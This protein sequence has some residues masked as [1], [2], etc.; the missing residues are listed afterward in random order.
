MTTYAKDPDTTERYGVNWADRLAADHATITGVGWTAAPTGLTLSD[1]VHTDTA[2]STLVAGGVPG[3]TYALTCR[4]TTSDGQ[5]LD[6][7]VQIVV[8]ST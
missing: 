8:Q 5:V 6:Y 1:P 4:I 3:T 2:A 7:T